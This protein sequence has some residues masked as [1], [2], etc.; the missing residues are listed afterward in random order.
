MEGLT[1]KIRGDW[2]DLKEIADDLYQLED[3]FGFDAERLQSIASDVRMAVERGITEYKNHATTGLYAFLDSYQYDSRGFDTL[4]KHSGAFSEILY[5]TLLQ[6]LLALGIIEIKSARP[7]E[8]PEK[9]AMPGVKEIMSDIQER[10]RKDP[11][12]KLNQSVKNILMQVNI[13]KKEL[14]EM[15][16]LEPKILPEKK[17]SFLINFR[18]RFAEITDKIQEHYR[19]IVQADEKEAAKG[20]EETNPLKRVDLK[21]IGKLLFDQA[22]EISALRSTLLFAV[23]ERFR[24]RDILSG[25]V[26][27]R[28]RTMLLLRLE[29]KGYADLIGSDDGTGISKAFAH[30]LIRVLTRQIPRTTDL[31]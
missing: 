2:F 5:V 16:E 30:E 4:A 3:Y 14:A 24:T 26:D 18:K 17:D 7:A 8:E 12:V 13:Y 10:I 9:P 27:R 25:I 20:F 6:R 19:V 28:D 22:E 23:S 1:K 21:P 31:S 29:R 15:K 11:N